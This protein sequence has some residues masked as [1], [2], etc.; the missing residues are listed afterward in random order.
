MN[1]DTEYLQTIFNNTLKRSHTMIKLVS[2][3]ECK[4]GSTYTNQET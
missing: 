2:F 4:D 1:I 3:R